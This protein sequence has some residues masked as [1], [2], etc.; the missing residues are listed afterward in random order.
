M[1]K[2]FSLDTENDVRPER[3]PCAFSRTRYV[4]PVT[5]F[6]AV[7]RNTGALGDNANENVGQILEDQ[8]SD[9]GNFR[10]SFLQMLIASTGMDPN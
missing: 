8:L 9:Q 5:P 6:V 2:H 7:C 4:T 10:P 3:M 1:D